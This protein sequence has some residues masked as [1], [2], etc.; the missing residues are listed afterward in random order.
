MN[1]E[2]PEV[3]LLESAMAAIQA[4]GKAGPEPDD[5]QEP[6]NTAYEADE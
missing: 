2:K 4:Q 3:V 1:Y 6:T 5:S